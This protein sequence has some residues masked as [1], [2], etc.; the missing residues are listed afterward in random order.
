M[1]ISRIPMETIC[2]DLIGPLPETSSGN[3][4]A[5]TAIC[6]L[7]NY[8]FMVPI[9]NKTTQQVIQAYLKHI[10]AQ[11]GGSRYILTDRGSEFTSQMMHQL[12]SELGFVKI[13]SSPYTPTGNSIIE[14]A[15]QFLKHS[16][17]KII[18]DKQVEWD[19]VCHIA[20]MAF[21]I[22]PTRIDQESPFFLMFHRDCFLP[23]LAQ[24]LQ[25]KLRYIGDS[26]MHTS[27]DAIR[28]LYMMNIMS[29]K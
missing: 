26:H 13:F 22:F 7:T 9:P 14:R 19:T 4:F 6:L 21:N 10:Y 29:L 16:I 12:A 27:L 18:N 8:V 28:E 15:H 5:L 24:F 1:P 3:K 17:S 20:A 23:T 2:M 25:P 11:F